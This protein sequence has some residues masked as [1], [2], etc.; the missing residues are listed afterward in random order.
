LSAIAIYWCAIGEADGYVILALPA[1]FCAALLVFHVMLL[2]EWER[3][4]RLEAEKRRNH[5]KPSSKAST[6]KHMR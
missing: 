3:Y 2:I 5:R 6:I 1:V 4:S